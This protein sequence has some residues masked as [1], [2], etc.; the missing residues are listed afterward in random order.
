MAKTNQCR[1][2]KV[3]AVV[4]VN[5]DCQ[6]DRAWALRPLPELSGILAILHCC[7]CMIPPRLHLAC[8]L[9]KGRGYGVWKIKWRGDSSCAGMGSPHLCCRR[10]LG[11][12]L[13]GVHRVQ[14]SKLPLTHALSVS[15]PIEL[16][17]SQGR[18]CYR[19]SLVYC[20]WGWVGEA[21]LVSPW[22]NV[23]HNRNQCRQ[24]MK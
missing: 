5:I 19:H 13:L 4:I 6:F 8:G 7:L 20:S 10:V 1:G 11:G 18:F 16:T 23:L 14:S 9:G 2:W 3:S 21:V 22:G 12:K 24:G 17:V 15:K